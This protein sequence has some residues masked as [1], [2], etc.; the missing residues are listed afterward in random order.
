MTNKDVIS[1]G[2]FRQNAII[3]AAIA[4]AIFWAA[5]MQIQQEEH[6][7]TLIHIGNEGSII[8]HD[9]YEFKERQA[10]D[11]QEIKG[12]IKEIKAIL[13]ERNERTH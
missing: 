9:L 2:F 6:Q 1:W 8:K 10:S 13:K 11:V 7:Q 4:G 3:I 12:D 5:R